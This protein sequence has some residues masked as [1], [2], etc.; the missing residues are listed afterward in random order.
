MIFRICLLIT[1]LFFTAGHLKAG[2]YMPGEDLTYEVSYLGIKLGSIR[3]ISEGEAEFEGSPVYRA[4]AVIRSYSGIPFVNL[5]VIYKSWMDKS[6]NFS[7][8][9]E[10]NVK[11]GDEWIYEELQFEYDKGAI[12]ASRWKN[13]KLLDADTIAIEKKYNEGMSL[14]FFARDKLFSKKRI[15]IPCHISDTTT[16]TISFYGRK[17]KSEIDA[18]KYPVK[19]VYF[20]GVLEGEGVYGMTGK[21][22]GWFSDDD[23]KVPIKA[24]VRVYVGN[25][26]IELISWKRNG[27]KPPKAD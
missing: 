4:K 2:T 22:E 25:V 23:A 15:R 17:E 11:D 27:W 3:I 13:N 18:V 14:F 26:N 6:L 12:E 8:H 1:F 20:S 9:F 7:R 24:K 10:S 16:T 21:F 19:T 5:H